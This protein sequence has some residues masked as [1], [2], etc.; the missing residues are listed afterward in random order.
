MLVVIYK[1]VR[2]AARAYALA[3]DLDLVMHFNDATN[4]AE[5]NGRVF[6]FTRTCLPVRV[7]CP[8]PL[9]TARPA[10][11]ASPIGT[12]TFF[13]SSSAFQYQRRL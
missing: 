8:I 6:Y 4:A 3:H 11:E 1:D 12:A 10:D 9:H 5:M 13:R 7:G 2:E